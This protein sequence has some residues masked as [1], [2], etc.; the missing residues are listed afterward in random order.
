MELQDEID[1][2]S[3]LQH[4]NIVEYLGYEKTQEGIY[5]FLEYV[6]G[7]SISQMLKRFG[8]FSESVIQSYLK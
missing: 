7:G 2:L 8:K 6:G 4:K 1:I 5:I 3:S